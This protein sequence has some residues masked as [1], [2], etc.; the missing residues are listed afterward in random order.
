MLIQAFFS[1]I[2]N[3]DTNLKLILVGDGEKKSEMEDLVSKSEYGQFV[4]FTGF[5]DGEKLNNYKSLID[6]GV[7]PGSNWYG[8]PTKVFEYGACRIASIVP[9]TP[10]IADIFTKDEVGFF[11][12]DDQE[13]LN[14]ILFELVENAGKRSQMASRLNSKITSTYNAEIAKEFY[15]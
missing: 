15:I 1:I 4:E 11:K 5:V 8:I 13:S 2:K 12:W 3:G 7:M 14:V 9:D 10:T 6:I